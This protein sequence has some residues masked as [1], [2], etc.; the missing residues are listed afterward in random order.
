M[1]IQSCMEWDPIW[2]LKTFSRK[3]SDTLREKVQIRS[4]F[5]SVFTRIPTEY[6][7]EFLRSDNVVYCLI[8]SRSFI[9]PFSF[10]PHTEVCPHVLSS[11]AL[12]KR[13][14][15]YHEAAIQR[16]GVTII[17][18]VVKSSVYITN[19]STKFRGVFRTLPNIYHG[20]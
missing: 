13:L 4:F 5:L 16:Q 6:G 12:V 7:P 3:Q 2:R 18:N 15:K 11:K 17:Q 20:P 10:I 14:A 9:D 8:L 1:A 19:L